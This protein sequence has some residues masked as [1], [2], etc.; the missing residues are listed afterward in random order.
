MKPSPSLASTI[1][2]A[3]LLLLLLL[4]LLLT[5]L[6]V[7]AKHCDS[8]KNVCYYTGADGKLACINLPI[9]QPFGSG[10][11]CYDR[12]VFWQCR[13][14]LPGADIHCRTKCPH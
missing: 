8:F 3:T 2:T 12:V 13:C 10:N 6:T 9:N 11:Y 4:L 5:A 7:V 14:N 1:L